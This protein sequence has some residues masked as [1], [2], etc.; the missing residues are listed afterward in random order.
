MVAEAQAGVSVGPSVYDSL[1]SRMT[2]AP[3]NLM[4]AYEQALYFLAIG[5]R[6]A[7][8]DNNP[9]ST[10]L[11]QALSRIGTDANAVHDQVTWLCTTTGMMCPSGGSG[12][13]LQE[14]I[15]EIERS[16]LSPDDVIQ[17]TT[18][19]KSNK[20]WFQIRQALPFV[21]GTLVLGGAAAWWWRRPR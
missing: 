7:L 8:R 9:T 19:L 17:I 21:V 16:G 18:H 4:V 10:S 20:R 11:S 13:V 14:A 2:S 5:V 12:A 6:R 1:D 15:D 3:K